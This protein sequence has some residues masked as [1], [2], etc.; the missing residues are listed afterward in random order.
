MVVIQTLCV[1][2][3]F[4]FRLCH[5]SDKY[6]FSW[7]NKEDPAMV[8][9]MALEPPPVLPTNWHEQNNYATGGTHTE[10]Q[11]IGSITPRQ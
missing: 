5:I 2:H 4:V 6:I 1:Q 10:V 9:I 7:H 3:F 11:L 8:W